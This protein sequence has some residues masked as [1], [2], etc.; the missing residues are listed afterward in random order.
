M[1]NRLLPGALLALAVF[2][3]QACATKSQMR[4]APSDAGIKQTYEFPIDKVRMAV[5]DA[6]G[7]SGFSIKEK[8]SHSLGEN[9]FEINASQGL[10]A[11]STGRRAR[12]RIEDQKTQCV[13]YVLVRSKMET[14]EAA[15][16][17]NALAEDIHKNLAKRLK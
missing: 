1:R 16:G 3:A 12:I 5:H 8:E 14:Q 9:V 10:A 2:G 15:P 17:D 6:V 7:E 11:G 4:S 13:V